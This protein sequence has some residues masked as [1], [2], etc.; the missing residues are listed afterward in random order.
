MQDRLLNFRSYLN[1]SIIET[2]SIWDLAIIQMFCSEV[3]NPTQLKIC[4]N[5]HRDS[6][7]NCKSN[8]DYFWIN[9]RGTYYSLRQHVSDSL[10]K[11][12]TYKGSLCVDSRVNEN[13]VI[14]F[15]ENKLNEEFSGDINQA[16][17]QDGLK[18][19]VLNNIAVNCEDVCRSY[20]PI[21]SYNLRGCNLS[22]ID[23]ATVMEDLV[24][25]CKLSCNHENPLGASQAKPSQ[26]NDPG[27]EYNSFENVLKGIRYPYGSLS[28]PSRGNIY[29][30]GICD[31][32]LITMP[33][34][35]GHD[36]Y[37][38][39]SFAA[40][41]CACNPE[42][43]NGSTWGNASCSDTI[44]S[45][46]PN[47]GDC[48]NTNS[49]LDN[50]IRNLIN[51]IKNNEDK[52]KCKNCIDCDVFKISI[53]AFITKYPGYKDSSSENSRLLFTNYLNQSFRFN[54]TYEDYISYGS[55]CIDTI[56][57]YDAILNKFSNSLGS[58]GNIYSKVL[59]LPPSS[60]YLEGW[61][62]NKS[63]DTCGCN[64]ILKAEKDYANGLVD[65]NV[66]DSP[67]SYVEAIFNCGKPLLDYDHY[68]YVCFSAM[69]GLA[70]DSTL[71]EYLSGDTLAKSN[72]GSINWSNQRYYP[73]GGLKMIKTF[74][75]PTDSG[76]FFEPS[77]NAYYKWV[78]A[79][80]L[81]ATA[82][83]HELGYNSGKDNLYNLNSCNPP[84]CCRRLCNRPIDE[85][86]IVKIDP[87]KERL[88]AVAQSNA[89]EAYKHYV[90]SIQ[91]VFRQSYLRKCLRP[92][93]IENMQEKF[94]LPQYHYTLYYYDQAGNLTKTIPPKGVKPFGNQD[95]NEVASIRKSNGTISKTPAHQ[96]ATHYKYNTQNSPTWQKTPDA[97]VSIFYY[98][99]LGRLVVSQNAKQSSNPTKFSYTKFDNLGRIIEV[100]EITN[101]TPMTDGMA[102]DQV[103]L[104]SWLNTNNLNQI[105]KTYYDVANYSVVDTILFKPLNLRNRVVYSTYQA[106][107]GSG[108]DHAVHYS[109][110]VHGN[111]RQ[112]LRE[113]KSLGPLVQDYKIVDYQY[114]LISGK[115][116]SVYYQSKQADQYY[117]QYFYDMANRLVNVESGRGQYQLDQDASYFYY[118]HGPLA[119]IELGRQ[120]VQ[121]IDY[122]YTIQG[123]L[124]GVN[125]GHLVSDKDIGRDGYTGSNGF[126]GNNYFPSDEY[127]FNL[128]YFE[129]DYKD[130]GEVNSTKRFVINTEGSSINSQAPNLF[131]GNIRMMG[132][133]LRQFGIYPLTNAYKYDQLNRILESNTWAAYDSNLNSY[134]TSAS[135]LDDYR[136][137]F[138]Y[139]ENGN[140]MQ[141]LRNGAGTNI[142]L[143]SM[144][145]DYYYEANEPT[146]KLKHIRD[147]VNSTNYSDDIDNQTNSNNYSYDAIGNLISDAQEEIAEISWNVYG[148]ISK[149]VRTQNSSKPDLE[150]EY[151]PDGYRVLKIVKPKNGNQN[152][153]TYYVRDAQGNILATYNRYY[154]KTIDFQNLTYQKVNDSNIKYGGL[155][156]LASFISQGSNL[157]G[158]K[159][160]F[161]TNLESDTNFLFSLNPFYL[162][163]ESQGAF[164]TLLGNMTN[165]EYF[166][167][168]FNINPDFAQLCQCFENRTQSNSSFSNLLSS[169]MQNEELLEVLLYKMADLY[170]AG[171]VFQTCNN[172][173]GYQGVLADAINDIRNYIF[174]NPGFDQSHFD[175]IYNE[176]LV[177]FPNFS[178]CN[179][180]FTNALSGIYASDQ[181][182]FSSN[183][184]ELLNIRQMF[185]DPN[186]TNGYGCDLTRTKMDIITFLSTNYP[187]EVWRI[188]LRNNN[189]EEYVRI[190]KNTFPTHFIE[191]SVMYD[192]ALLSAYQQNNNIYGG[193]YGGL[194]NYFVNMRNN[195]GQSLYDQIV[196]GFL[197]QSSIFLDSMMLSEWHIYGSSRI[198]IYNANLCMATRRVKIEE[199]IIT[200]QENTNVSYLSYSYYTISRGAKRYELTNHLGNV[201]TV[202]SDK[203]IPVCTGEIVSFFLADVV[204][205]TDYSPFGAPLPGRTWQASEYRFAF[206]GKEKDDETYGD[207]N[208][209]DFGARIY[210]SRLGKWFSRDPKSDFY[211]EI[212]P[213]SYA[214]L[215]PIFM[216]DDGGKEVYVYWTF[217]AQN[218][219]V[220]NIK[221]TGIVINSGGGSPTAEEITNAIL[222]LQKEMNVLYNNYAD[223][224]KY[225]FDVNIKLEFRSGQDNDIKDNDHT[226][227]LVKESTMINPDLPSG[228]IVPAKVNHIGGR[229]AYFVSSRYSVFGALLSN[230]P[231][232]LGHWLGL[233]HPFETNY[234]ASYSPDNFMNWGNGNNSSNGFQFLQIESFFNSNQLNT[235]PP[236]GDATDPFSTVISM[237]KSYS[238]KLPE[239]TYATDPSSTDNRNGE[240]KRIYENRTRGTGSGIFHEY[241]GE[242]EDD[243]QY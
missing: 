52:Y 143:D 117:H 58:D 114:D 106:N 103:S 193:N 55:D 190:Y 49:T 222:D 34:P 22:A 138:V 41:T 187:N 5:I 81:P 144:R 46:N 120:K 68:K 128:H 94:Q 226:I 235:G 236:F 96:M 53:F 194:E 185:Y 218:K 177:Q 133:A 176:I 159:S 10:T 47:C 142:D 229:V 161:I 40:D 154:S 69:N 119:R 64:I 174:N 189:C 92:H 192:K 202:V 240:I 59:L 26:M 173:I 124:K 230:G 75:M 146:N 77:M 162:L 39:N 241:K 51:G 158:L 207:G 129:G 80:S 61:D 111:V 13:Y 28:S 228:D 8:Q 89:A 205:A 73:L 88:K 199:G 90:D 169:M 6:I 71:I 125:S 1:G 197:N 91:A 191:Q 227:Y 149:I 166:N 3:T 135:A 100:G 37:S 186:V 184:G 82:V 11:L 12:Y 131:N 50:S 48:E 97:G 14:R 160:N 233:R 36:Y 238:E 93:N 234:S 164:D 178:N 196:S 62:R 210:D 54:L 44:Q 25:V 72:S 167:Y 137:S 213:Y 108:Y 147:I 84:I 157:N 101:G 45:I 121:G 239:E 70:V 150:F 200:Q 243:S 181:A 122:A 141:Q 232:E 83:L 195:F 204:S 87:C 221:I 224:E 206:N 18:S 4:I 223:A 209:L 99:Q 43:Y 32:V 170:G 171:G 183:M 60:P 182:L 140:I 215:N 148:K 2:F 231:H 180:E 74:A 20:I 203:K 78:P 130:I 165:G 24:K 9:F 179:T 188:M 86:D 212:S 65:T 30:P 42:E 15:P 102:R 112:L 211:P 208:T 216:I 219:P 79:P 225:L 116:N 168:L 237:R 214:M 151:T 220:L 7:V 113:I 134:Q 57:S 85:I 105:T 27:L 217:N 23:S 109:Y 17:G 153:Y 123:W 172:H 132:V 126:N 35:Y 242:Q 110:D 29:V 16:T 152:L 21:W 76:A 66:Y 118:L 107:N 139:D 115:V 95:A 156:G 145:Y 163:N 127:G 63:I 136:N 104:A 201:L 198:G 98:D 56:A 19:Q 67:K 33:M 155:S 31:E 38:T 175:N